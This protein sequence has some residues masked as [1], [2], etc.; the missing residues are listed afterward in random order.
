MLRKFLFLFA[1]VGMAAAILIVA[2][3]NRSEVQDPV[4]TSVAEPA[5]TAATTASA[6]AEEH[7]HAPGAHG[8]TI[9]SLG[10]DSYHAEAVFEQGGLV[11]LYMLGQDETRVQE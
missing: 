1:A 5:P 11:R 6:K 9:V 4:T 8:G 10:R 3:C 7:G 2:G